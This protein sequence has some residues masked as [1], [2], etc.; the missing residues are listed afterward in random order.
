MITMIA[1]NCSPTRQRISFCDR[2]GTAAAQH[3]GQSQ[4]KHKRHRQKRGA[5]HQIGKLVHSLKS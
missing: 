5:G 4:K 3:V 2:F 1:T